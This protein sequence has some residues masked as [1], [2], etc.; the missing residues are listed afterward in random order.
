MPR[1]VLHVRFGP[2]AD[3]DWLCLPLASLLRRDRTRTARLDYAAGNALAGCSVG[4]GLVIVATL[5]DHKSSAASMEYGV[6]FALFE[7]VAAE[8]EMINNPKSL[9]AVASTVA[10]HR[11][12][13]SHYP[14]KP[15]PS[16]ER[17]IKPSSPA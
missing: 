4:I 5:M 6:L 3:I 17:A 9:F 10:A 8:L 15:S 14:N 2:Q 12:D 16:L 13:R 11:V 1:A 7:Q